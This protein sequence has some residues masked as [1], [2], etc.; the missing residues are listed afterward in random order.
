MVATADRKVFRAN[1]EICTGCHICELV[2]SMRQSSV[3]SPY[4]AC[5]RVTPRE[6]DGTFVP[7]ICR[8]C[9]RPL[10]K[11]ACPVPEAMVMHE[12][13]PGVVVINAKECIGCLACADACP[14]GA[15]QVSA[16]QEPLKCDL[17]DGD[18]LCVKYCPDRPDNFNPRKPF[19]AGRALEYVLPKNATR[20][21]RIAIVEKEGG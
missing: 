17:C 1:R 12:T 19:P 6:E 18:P 14:F 8:H 5:I 10:C 11:E 20:A 16:Q 7:S 21:K 3:M 2:C 15:I 9:T 4:K 13:L